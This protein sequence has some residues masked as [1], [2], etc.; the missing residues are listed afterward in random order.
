MQ[1]SH[2][3]VAAQAGELPACRCRMRRLDGADNLPV[4][5]AT[6]LLGDLPAM[7]FDLDIVLVAAR[8]EEK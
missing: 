8:R 7:R 3:V 2:R 4:T 5:R 6:G 1:M